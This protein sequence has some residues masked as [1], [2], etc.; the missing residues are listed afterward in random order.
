M[1]TSARRFDIALGADI[2]QR[3]CQE[4][5]IAAR[6]SS[7]KDIGYVVVADGMGGHQA[8]DIASRLVASSWSASMDQQIRIEAA[9]ER[10]LVD[11]LP[12][13]AMEANA[14]I[15]SHIEAQADSKNMGSTL[16]GT[17]FVENRFYWISIGDSP[18]YLYRGG[19]LSQINEDHSMAPNLDSLAAQGLL[20]AEDAHVHPDRNCLT[21]ALMGGGIAR[22]DCPEHPKEMREGD[23]L[24]AASDGIQHLAD[25]EIETI[26]RTENHTGCQDILDQIMQALRDADVPDKDNVSVA[27][28]ALKQSAA[29]S[30]TLT[31]FE[32][33][34][35]PS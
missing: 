20:S 24:I 26:L 12:L 22:V 8:G 3:D 2:G 27:I 10:I 15:A 4:D 19:V 1:T 34:S 6:F 25:A 31:Q 32:T 35:T 5:A 30:Q 9:P 18:L 28:V 21:S 16:L 11:A 29:D 33:N 7:T 23:I 17:L 13:A 14:A